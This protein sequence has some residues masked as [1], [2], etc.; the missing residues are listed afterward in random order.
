VQAEP[1][2][3]VPILRLVKRYPRFFTLRGA[4]TVLSGRY[5]PEIYERNLW[6]FKG[7]GALAYWDEECIEEA[8]LTMI[9]SGRLR[10]FTWGLWKGMLQTLR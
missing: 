8:V 4:V 10:H 1:E 5:K 9:R 2:G 6:R 3:A 7:F